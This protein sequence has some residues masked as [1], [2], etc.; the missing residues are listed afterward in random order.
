ME[1]DNQIAEVV[2]M[3]QQ[4]NQRAHTVEEP[5]RAV[6]EE[7]RRLLQYDNFK[8]VPGIEKA[9]IK[10]DVLQDEARSFEDAAIRYNI[11]CL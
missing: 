11:H 10:W 8:N 9:D 6:R 4:S 1:Q 3:V 7:Q 5:G 2:P